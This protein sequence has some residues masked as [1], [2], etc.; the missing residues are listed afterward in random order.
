MK[1]VLNRAYGGFSLP[2]EYA[3][4]TDTDFYDSS[5]EVRTDPDLIEYVTVHPWYDLKVIEFPDEATDFDIQEYDGYE[6]LI[7][8]IDGKI[9]Y[10]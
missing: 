2:R 7:Y 1:I 5:F 10:V 8:V 3:E 6:K 4:A 9:H